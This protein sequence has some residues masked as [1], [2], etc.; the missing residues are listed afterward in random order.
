MIIYFLLKGLSV[1]LFGD[2]YYDGVVNVVTHSN[3]Q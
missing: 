2:L 1:D 3:S